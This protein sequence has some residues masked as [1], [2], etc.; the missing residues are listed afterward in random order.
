LYLFIDEFSEYYDVETGKKAY[1]LLQR[2]G[3]EVLLAPH[4]ESGR[5][6]ISK[7][8]LDEAAEIAK[9]NVK[10]F[11]PLIDN[12]TPLVGIEPSAILVFKDEYKRLT[13]NSKEAVELAENV[14]TFEGFIAQQYTAGRI[15]PEDFHLEDKNIHVHVHCHQKSLIG[16]EEVKTAL[17]IPTNYQV[18]ILQ[19][20]CCGMAGAFGYE[21][22][23]YSFS[24]K[25]G[26]TEVFPKVREI[27]SDATL[28]VSGTSC[29]HQIEDGTNKRGIHTAEILL[30]ALKNTYN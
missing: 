11:S 2:L 1:E 15:R 6:Y 22:K 23:H 14:L 20:G 17:S 27:K 30:K 5:A 24:M 13:G 7:G 26:E 25:V 3:Y 19:T 28:A 9:Y 8:L 29:R 4:R 12:N 18:E 16:I 10:L 21:Q